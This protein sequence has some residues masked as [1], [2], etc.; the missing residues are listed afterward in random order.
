MKLSLRTY[1]RPRCLY[2]RRSFKIQFLPL[3]GLLFLSDGL[4][5][6]A[7]AT[8]Y[9][10]QRNSFLSDVALVET[11]NNPRAVGSKDE[12]GLYQFT[13]QTWRQHTKLSHYKAHDPSYSKQ[14]AKKHYDW[15]YN[16]LSL[17][18][19][20]PSAYWLAVAWNT[21]LK[22]TVTGRFPRIS[23]RYAERVKI[24]VFNDQRELLATNRRSTQ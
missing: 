18:G 11:G 15:L 24:L 5:G 19:Y 1:L 10:A 20:P 9:E 7:R 6:Q 21:G 2:I 13:R 17:K 14:I 3:L 4:V 23:R 16:N 12:R 22:R 8:N